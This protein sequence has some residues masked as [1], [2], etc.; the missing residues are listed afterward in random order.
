MMKSR[1][2]VTSA[3]RFGRKS[4]FGTNRKFPARSCWVVVV[5]SSADTVHRSRFHHCGPARD[6]DYQTT[7][8]TLGD[9]LA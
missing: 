6:D 3:E 4:V 7:Q 2:Y 5:S 9:S 1:E 8:M